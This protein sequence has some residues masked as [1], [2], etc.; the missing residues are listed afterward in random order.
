MNHQTTAPAHSERLHELL[1]DNG[2]LR[3]TLSDV[4]RR[5]A[6]SDEMMADLTHPK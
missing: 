6:L 3:I 4:A 1:D 5:N 2:V